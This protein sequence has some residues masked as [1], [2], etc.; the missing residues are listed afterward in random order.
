VAASAGF[1]LLHL[2]AP[3]VAKFQRPRHLQNPWFVWSS[4]IALTGAAIALP[5]WWADE[6]RHS[7]HHA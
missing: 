7:L 4:Y 1:Q 5:A 6:V 3:G 2:A